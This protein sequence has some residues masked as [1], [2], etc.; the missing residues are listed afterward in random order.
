[1]LSAPSTS[2]KSSLTFESI[3]CSQLELK[4]RAESFSRRRS[5]MCQ[6]S[7]NHHLAGISSNRRITSTCVP[8]KSLG[9]NHSSLS[10]A[11]DIAVQFLNIRK[12][13]DRKRSQISSIHSIGPGSSERLGERQ[14]IVSM[15]YWDPSSRST[16]IEKV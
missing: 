7:S 3:V 14:S 12:I 5:T 11:S 16:A 6:R 9:N 10:T 8:S 15:L 4:R 1:M 13:N 2:H